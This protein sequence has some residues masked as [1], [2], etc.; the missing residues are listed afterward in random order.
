[1]CSLQWRTQKISDG[2]PKDRRSQ[3][4]QRGHY[5]TKFLEN[6]VIL[7]FERR[8]SLTKWC[9]S[10]K[11]KHF[12][13]HCRIL[14]VYTAEYCLYIFLFSGSEGGGHGTVPPA[15][16]L[17]DPWIKYFKCF[18]H[19][20]FLP[21]VNPLWYIPVMPIFSSISAAEDDPR[22]NIL[23][24]HT[25]GL[26]AKKNSV[27]EQLAYKNKAFIIVLQETHCTT[28]DKLVIPNFSLAG[29][30]LSRNQVFPRLSTS[31]WNGHWSISLQNYQSLSGYVQTSQD[32]RSSTS[33]NLHARDSHLRPSRRSHTPSCILATSTAN[34]STGV[35]TK[36]LLMVR[37]WTPGQH[38]TTLDCCMTQRKQP[39]SPLTDGM[40]EQPGPDL[41][42]F[43]PGQATA[44]QTC[45]WKVPAVTT[46]VLPHTVT[47]TQ[48]SCPQRSGEASELPQG[49]LEAL[50]PSHRWIRW[51]IAISEQ[52]KYWEGMPGFLRE[53][54]FCSQ[55]MYPTWPSQ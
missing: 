3:G 26:T 9:Y 5:P 47:E 21:E 23:Q 38:P 36:H 11:A 6:I 37:A 7:C 12:G 20:N 4:G 34:M 54:T 39:V 31:G 48:G 51:E 17:V 28:A 42:E 53:P 49:W 29:S 24:L 43:R 8:F 13:I 50:L 15:R 22:H 2:G 19:S 18:L 30:V 25:E 16:T 35:T 40:S 33:T 41:R 55:T 44:G 14:A 1:M 46:A 27:I 32:I 45:S 10:P 52:I